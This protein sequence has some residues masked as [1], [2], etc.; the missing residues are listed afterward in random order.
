MSPPLQGTNEYP[1]VLDTMTTQGLIKSRAFSLDLRGV[2][3]PN[4]A[5]IFG[6]VDT[7]KYI[8]D[9][10][11]LPMLSPAQSP[12]GSDRYYITLTG[13]GLT[14]P[15]GETTQ[16]APISVPIFLDSGS[17]FS[18]LPTPIYQA[19]A[20]SFTDAQYDPASGYY[21]VPCDVTNLA[22]SIDFY[23]GTK[24]IRVP[25]NDFV[26]EVDGYC[27]LG[28]LPD[29]EEPILGDTFLRAAYVV[30]DQDNRN[31]HLAQA[32]D[33]GSELVAIGTGKDAVPSSKGKCTA[34]PTAT[35]GTATTKSGGGNLDVTST[36]APT[37]TFT[38]A[39]PTVPLGPGP[40]ASRISDSG[41]TAIPQA[42]GGAGSGGGGKNAAGRGVEV[43][44]GAVL[45]WAGVHALMSV[46]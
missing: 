38:G 24:A 44:L 36:R 46:L 29:D 28:I 32:A 43:G 37:N 10:A 33:C 22:G 4:G 20:E 15:S 7:A 19:F 31:I 17:T 42:T 3:N 25:I 40:A 23:F 34:L 12:G 2:D 18:H 27:V 1:Y 39:A 30:F 6:G 5:I 14:L 9:L 16:S 26:W 41:S 13:V 11:K 35:A 8:G 45:A 21:F